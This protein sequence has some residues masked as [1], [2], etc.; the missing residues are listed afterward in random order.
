MSQHQPADPGKSDE[1]AAILRM[2]QIV[3]SGD[4]VD[5]E[6]FIGN[7]ECSNTPPSLF[8]ENTTQLQEQR[9]V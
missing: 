4:E 5:I 3:A 6:N 9:P 1:V 8:N 2:T 7:H